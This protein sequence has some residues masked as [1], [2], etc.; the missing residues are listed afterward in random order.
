[1]RVAV[2]GALAARPLVRALGGRR[3]RAHPALDPQVAAVLELERIARIPAMDSMEPAAARK[4]AV[5]GLSPLDPDPEPMDRVIDVTV[6]GPASSIP[7]RIYVP[8]GAGRSWIVYFHGGGGVIGS[9]AASD[10]ATRLIAA[11]TRCTV[12]SVDYRCGPEH[13]HPAAIDDAVAAF[14]AIAA[15]V[16]AGGRI[17]VSGDSF[18]GYLAVRVEHA[19]R[20]RGRGRRSDAQGLFYPIVD[21]TFSS[22]SLARNAEGYLLTRSLIDWF[23]RHYVNPGDDRRAMSP[24]LWADGELR[25]AA[26]MVMSTA[27]FDPLVDE[28]DAY[29]E[30]LA[31]LGVAVH[32]HRNA[33]LIHGFLSMSGAVHAARAAVDELCDDVAALLTV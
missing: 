9:I 21:Y 31:K 24:L 1:M 2:R 16:P 6:P 27:G 25:G 26:P 28:G 23:T 22:P 14:D 5:D 32:H 18:G 19:T 17:A 33:G 13:K 12:A 10:P 29:A 15:R 7:V 8:P 4:F 3:V 20:T 11:R 30:R